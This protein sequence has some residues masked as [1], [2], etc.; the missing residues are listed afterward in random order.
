VRDDLRAY[1]LSN[2]GDPAGVVVADETV[3]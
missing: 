3:F 2:L 1:V